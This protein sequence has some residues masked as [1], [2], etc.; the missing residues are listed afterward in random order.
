MNEKKNIYNLSYLRYQ[1]NRSPLRKWVRG[2]YLK[3]ILNNVLGRAVDFG[4]GAG[5]LLELLGEGSLGF[6]INEE[7]VRYCKEAGFNVMLWDKGSPN[8]LFSSFEQA[9]FSTFILNHVLEHIDDPHKFIMSVFE[10]CAQKGFK[11]I[12]I[13]VPGMKGFKN[14]PSHMHFIGP[15]FFKKLSAE[16]NADFTV[17]KQRFFPLN[18]VWAG[19]IF[20][21]NESVII[22][23]RK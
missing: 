8:D 7:A 14:D 10:G 19:N 2:F 15:E 9:V 13:I 17:K 3:N 12:I 16:P 18:A 1:L 6:E 21:H 5:E 23:D 20:T 22:F 4:C 11:R